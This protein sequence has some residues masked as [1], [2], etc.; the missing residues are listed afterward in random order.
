[1]SIDPENFFSRII[2]S[3]GALTADE[4]VFEVEFDVVFEVVDDA[5]VSKAQ[6]H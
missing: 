5:A 1:M 2:T 6:V 3:S 4:V